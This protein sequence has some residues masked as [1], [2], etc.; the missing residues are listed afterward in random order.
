VVWSFGDRVLFGFDGFWPNGWVGICGFQ[1]VVLSPVLSR[2]AWWFCVDFGHV[3]PCIPWF[4]FEMSFECFNRLFSVFGCVLLL[5]KQACVCVCVWVSFV[6]WYCLLNPCSWFIAC[7]PSAGHVVLELEVCY[8]NSSCPGG[9]DFGS[10][11]LIMTRSCVC[12]IMVLGV[13]LVPIV[14]MYVLTVF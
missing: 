3:I 9:D 12:D 4:W 7:V 6:I 13:L 5:I 2:M 1:L 11:K 8:P 14:F 10:W